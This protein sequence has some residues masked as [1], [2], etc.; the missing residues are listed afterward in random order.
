MPFFQT[1]G[2]KQSHAHK[3]IVD[4]NSPTHELVCICGKV[5]GSKREPVA[6]YRNRHTLYE[7]VAYHSAKEARYAAELDLRKRTGEILDWKGQVKI[8]LEVNG[9][10]ICNYYID[11]EVL[12]PGGLKE[13]VEVK[14]FE[15]DVWRL[16]W[17]LVNAIYKE[18][19][20]KGDELR[21]TLVK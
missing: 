1:R 3:Y 17:K 14:G 11:F 5:K 6:K 16:K 19:L 12:Y 13:W 2:R 4:F 15:T 7:G 9:E 8:P 18:E 21:L 20:E 10:H